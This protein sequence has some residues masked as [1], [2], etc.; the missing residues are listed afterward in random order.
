MK[1]MSGVE[2]QLGVVPG[3]VPGEDLQPPAGGF[4]QTLEKVEELFGQSFFR[5][6]SLSNTLSI[7]WSNTRSSGDWGPRKRQDEEEQGRRWLKLKN[8]NLKPTK[9]TSL[10]MFKN[11]KRK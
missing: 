5:S 2:E 7:L 8:D 1:S 9:T 6:T 4:L 3:L 10:E 11:E